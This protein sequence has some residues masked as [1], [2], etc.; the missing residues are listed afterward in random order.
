[1]TKKKTI[2]ITGASGFIGRH[3]VEEA[4]RR[5]YEVWAGVRRSSSTAHLPEAE[6][7]R[8]DLTLDDIEALTMQIAAYVREHGA[9]WDFVVH[10]AGL[11]KTTHPSDFFRVNAVYTL[12]LLNALATTPCKPGKFL[13]MS[14]LSACAGG[15]ANT[16]EALQ[17]KPS[18]PPDTLYGKSKLMAEKYVRAQTVMPYVILR[19]TGVYGPGDGDY[20]MQINALRAGF[21]FSV[22]LRDQC[23]TYIYVKDLARAVFFALESRDAHSRVFCVTDGHLYTADQAA[24]TILSVL[25]RRFAYPVVIPLWLARIACLCSDAIGRITGKAMTLNAD[26]YKILRRRGWNCDAEPIRSL[27][28]FTPHY[29]LRHGMQ[30][31]IDEL[32]NR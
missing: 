6:I 29:S 26:K 17:D 4:L 10:N 22:G 30:E 12:H 14:S 18:F 13:L 7:N 2:L 19:P 25:R 31:T 27:T 20:L 9:S 8:I 5:G 28:G 11:T 3:I 24:E 32:R 1:M 16:L 21:D 23:I 15:N